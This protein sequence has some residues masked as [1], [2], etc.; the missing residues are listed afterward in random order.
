MKTPRRRAARRGDAV[1]NW[2][3]SLPQTF[4]ECR[5]LGHV[6]RPWR[7]SWNAA[8]REYRRI[9]RCARCSTERTQ[10]LSA[11]GLVLKGSY[12]Y[13]DGYAKPEDTGHFDR[14][15]RAALRLESL[16]RLV[17][18]EPSAHLE[19]GELVVELPDDRPVVAPP[20]RMH[21]VGDLTAVRSAKEA[22]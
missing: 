19:S 11:G 4:I 10:S 22:S 16:L 14:S 18:D 21:A 7:A 8:E 2:I 1:G 6:W 3:Q 15:E 9:L 13:I 12:S 20:E 5:D 17:V